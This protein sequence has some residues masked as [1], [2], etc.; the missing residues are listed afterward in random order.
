MLQLSVC[1]LVNKLHGLLNT[2]PVKKKP[3]FPTLL[4]IIVFNSMACAQQ[5]EIDS[6]KNVLA[7]KKE[8]GGQLEFSF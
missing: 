6:L 5:G 8:T 2:F 1:T 4:L 7:Q 3:C